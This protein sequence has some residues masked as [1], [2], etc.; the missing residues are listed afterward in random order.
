MDLCSTK[1]RAEPIY[2]FNLTPILAQHGIIIHHRYTL[3][4]LDDSNIVALRLVS[5]RDLLHSYSMST[6][7]E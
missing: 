2:V 5:Y 1:A 7:S 3:S 4:I 6:K